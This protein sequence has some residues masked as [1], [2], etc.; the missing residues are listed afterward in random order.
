MTNFRTDEW[1]IDVVAWPRRCRTT[2]LSMVLAAAEGGESAEAA[3]AGLYRAYFYPVYALIAARRGRE[4]AEELTQAFFAERMILRNDLARF[5]PNKCRKF[6]NWL[7]TAVDSFLMNEWRAQRRKRRDVRKTLALDFE[8]A[9]IRFMNDPAIEPERR[10]ERAWA[11]CVLSHVIARLRDEYCAASRGA[12]RATAAARFDA[13]KAYLPG[14][15]LDESAYK[16]MALRLGMS[17]EAVKQR[18]Y[19]LRKRFGE[20]LR[21]HVAELV[22]SNAEIDEEIQFLYRALQLPPSQYDLHPPCLQ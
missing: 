20:Q 16:E 3:R 9:E 4:A 7:F 15:E 10:Y 2:H 6:R 22:A 11:L 8:A 19:Q 14:P 21:E 18:V 1:R 13:L 17:A 5:D 12:A